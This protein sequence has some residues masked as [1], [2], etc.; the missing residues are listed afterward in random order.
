MRHS[1][2]TPYSTNQEVARSKKKTFTS[3]EEIMSIFPVYGCFPL[4]SFSFMQ[5]VLFQF[6]TWLKS[7]LLASPAPIPWLVV[8]SMLGQEISPTNRNLYLELAKSQNC[9]KYND[10]I[11]KEERMFIRSSNLQHSCKSKSP[12]FYI[13]RSWF[14]KGTPPAHSHPTHSSPT[15]V[16][17]LF[18]YLAT[19]LCQ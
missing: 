8:N 5:Y 14:H 19:L 17:F 1:G 10:R 2:E 6:I 4:I 11:E 16:C 12:A 3:D 13:A 7:L 9:E 18:V 15:F